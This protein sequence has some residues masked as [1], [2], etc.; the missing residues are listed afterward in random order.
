MPLRLAQP[1]ISL[2]DLRMLTELF[3]EKWEDFQLDPTYEPERS[4]EQ[5]SIYPDPI[6][7]NTEKFKILQRY[8]RVN[9]VVPVDAPHMWHAAMFSKSCKLT[10]LG[11]RYWD[12]VK[13]KII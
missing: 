5:R 3:S 13:N 9:L 6:E 11:E 10:T 2:A 7:E 4:E 8:N 1:P 12:L